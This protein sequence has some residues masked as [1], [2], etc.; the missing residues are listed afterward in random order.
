MAT[1]REV[2]A[3]GQKRVYYLSLEFLIG[4]LLTDAISNLGL[5]DACRAALRELG[6]DFDEI[7]EL[8]PDAA[9]GNGGSGRLAACFMESMATLGVAAFG[10][11]IRYDH[12]LFRQAIQDGW[13]VE[14]PEDWLDYGNSVGV[15]ALGGRLPDRLRRPARGPATAR[16]HSRACWKPA[17]RVLAVA[18]DT[19]LVGWQGRRVNTLRLWSARALDPMRLDAF[20]RGDYI[21][22]LPAPDPLDEHHAACSTRRLRRRPARSCG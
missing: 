8:E 2:Y 15:R 16:R 7:K 19:P 6:V 3:T 21:A 13:Q 4:R 14:L 9:L 22:A 1:T 11:G 10:Y 5:T 12:G 17:E 20:N 18:H